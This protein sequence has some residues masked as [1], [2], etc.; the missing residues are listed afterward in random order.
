MPESEHRPRGE[1]HRL[2]GKL[3]LR[4]TFTLVRG[5]T[6]GLWHFAPQKAAGIAVLAEKIKEKRR[7]GWLVVAKVP[8]VL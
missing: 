8:G 5:G 2:L 1:C 6:H 7:T 4:G 3:D